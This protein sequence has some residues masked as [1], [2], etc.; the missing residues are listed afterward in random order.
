MAK[1]LV[2]A[3][4]RNGKLNDGTLE[5][6]KAAKAIAS[7]TGDTPAAAVF[8][9]DDSIAK[10]LS[11]YIPEVLSAVDAKFEYYT[12]DAYTQAIKS[13]VEGNDVKGVLI[14]HSYD[15]V[16]FAAKVALA[17]GAGIVSSVNKAE[18]SGGKLVFTR[19]IY[20]GKLQEQKTVKTDKFVATLEKAHGTKNR[21]VPQA[22]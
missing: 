6:C 10:E 11:K 9:K 21:Q 22:Q 16:D 3:E 2:I 14:V 1:I 18:F 13:V 15:G 12:A 17:I 8:A 4:H 20:N 7:A 19:N 5:L